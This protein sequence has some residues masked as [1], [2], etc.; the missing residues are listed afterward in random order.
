LASIT[1]TNGGALIT[2]R[3]EEVDDNALSQLR[4]Y[5]ERLREAQ[6]ELRES[7]RENERLRIEK[8]L[9]L[10]EVFPRILSK[11]TNTVQVLGPATAVAI[12][13][14]N[15]TVE[16]VFESG[17]DASALSSL[18]GEI[19]AFV[20]DLPRQ[21]QSSIEVND[22]IQR[23]EDDLARKD[24]SPGFVSNLLKSFQEQLVRISLNEATS[25]LGEHL[26]GILKQL[27]H[28]I[29]R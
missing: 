7:L 12:A 25:V 9:L 2:I 14:D 20:A 13:F 21:N 10:D 11:T 26:P 24:K 18:I 19:R 28:L 15:A 23:L 22:T 16:T 17:F 3:V 4:I 5:A 6:V 8:S 29:K 27:D 1:E